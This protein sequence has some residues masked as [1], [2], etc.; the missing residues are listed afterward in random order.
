MHSTERENVEENA[1]EKM[2]DSYKTGTRAIEDD[3]DYVAEEDTIS[4]LDL[5]AVLV[6][7]RKLIIGMTLGGALLIV[8]I[9]ILTI[10]LPPDS[11]WN[12]LPNIYEPKVEVLV[13]GTTGTSSISQMLSSSSG[14]G[15]LAGLMG[16]SGA[17]NTSAELAMALLEGNTIKDEIAKQFN[18]VKRYHIEKYPKTTARNIIQ[19]ALDTEYDSKTNI[20]TIGY[21]DIDPV[22]ATKVLNQIVKLLEK[23]FKDLTLEKVRIKKQFLKERLE[24]VGKD[25]K[26]AQDA[27]VNFQRKHG[28]VDIEAQAQEQIKLI[29]DLTSQVYSK[30][31]ELQTMKSY[32]RPNDPKIVR[33]QNEINKMNA[34][35]VELRKGFKEFSGEAI[36]QEKLPMVSAQYLNLKR[37]LKIQET[38]Y[39][40]LRQQY[41]TAKI[42]ETDTSQTFQILEHAEVPEVK[43]APSRSKICIIFTITVFFLAIFLAFVLEYFER[44]KKDPVESLKLKEIQAMIKR[45]KG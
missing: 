26:K 29:A 30:E 16:L 38:I 7:R 37:D 9:S 21:K 34:L 32:L 33:L 27:L 3:R 5:I 11:K 41:E 13:K 43:S 18:F 14:L 10:K 2:K 17:S 23:R 40:M 20:L 8:G 42:E 35:I 28:I 36:P 19:S 4:L 6:K 39:T 22:F 1:G 44:V 31:V 45:K 12:I 24:T 15:A 25:L